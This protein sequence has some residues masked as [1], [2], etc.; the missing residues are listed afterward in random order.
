M[1]D[2]Q[3]REQDAQVLSFPSAAERDE[4]PVL[5]AEVVDESTDNTEASSPSQ[6]EPGSASAGT[7]ASGGPR[8]TAATFA[9]SRVRPLSVAQA[10]GRYR[11]LSSLSKAGA[12]RIPAALS[13]KV[14]DRAR[15]AH[16]REGGSHRG[17]IL[18][19]QRSAYEQEMAERRQRRRRVG[20]ALLVRKTHVT[21]H[22][23]GRTRTAETHRPRWETVAPVA[24]EA[25]N[26][27]YPHTPLLSP[28]VDTVNGGLGEFLSALGGH[29]V[30]GI[31][32]A[33]AS[34][35]GAFAVLGASA[36]AVAWQARA[37]HRDRQEQLLSL[38]SAEGNGDL[39]PDEPADVITAA[40]RAAG[41]LRAPTSSSPGQR[42]ALQA[43]IADDG[44]SWTA[45]IAVAEGV[46]T[47]VVRG[48][49]AKLA[50]ALDRSLPQIAVMD[51]ASERRMTLRVWHGDA[52]PFTGEPVRSPL[53]QASSTRLDQGIRIGL[54][55]DGQPVVLHLG[56]GRHG[57]VVA[58]SGNGK[59][60]LL[61]VIAGATVLDP[62]AK[63]T[64]LDGKPDGAYAALKD[65][66]WE[67]AT[68]AQLGCEERGAEVLEQVADDMDERLARAERGED[69]GGE[70][71]V[72]ID[73]FQEWTGSANGEGQKVG[74]PKHRMRAALERIARRGRSA[75]V[76]LVLAS[77]Q[78]DGRTLDDAVLTNIGWRAI[79]Y[80]PKKMS[81]DALGDL[82]E[83]YGLDTSISFVDEV[84]AGAMLVAGGGVHPYRSQRADMFT[85]ADLTAIATR[86]GQRQAHTGDDEGSDSD[87]QNC[88]EPL[89]GAESQ[90]LAALAIYADEDA[91][92]VT[93]GELYREVVEGEL[94]W[95]TNPST[96]TTVGTALRKAG[97]GK[98]V[99][100]ETV[101]GRRTSVTRYRRT[102]LTAAAD[103]LDTAA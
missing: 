15:L 67:Y 83:R 60:T 66:C 65:V 7:A 45:R 92:W 80:A 73:E 68:T 10:G 14:M 86:V 64:L 62:H 70:H 1:A 82:A 21:R 12:K 50:S 43:P 89:T 94:G 17:E 46:T 8:A 58:S 87:P 101:D 11:Y 59:T 102:E 96:R 18:P 85:G 77:Q 97:V 34:P 72:L 33:A 91:E 27:V 26:T 6:A 4:Q 90:L 79:G 44:Q 93:A 38:M 56:K 63:L 42:V 100:Q 55:A 32:A 20:K 99:N 9:P 52:L 35:G 75:R 13:D 39:M 78:Y 48:K 98:S 81:R 2:Q 61:Q 37:E 28:I 22:G 54:D 51:G 69:I 30:D 41:I 84:Q 57:L 25:V 31:T 23:M 74:W 24:A 88:P 16:L 71:V 3:Q 19:A 49:L 29:I 103:R 95:E 47:A 5:E 36:A 76:R 40:F 53:A